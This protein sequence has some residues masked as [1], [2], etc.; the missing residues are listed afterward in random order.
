M[1][2]FSGIVRG[3]RHASSS[4]SSAEHSQDFGAYMAR[5]SNMQMLRAI[6]PIGTLCR[7]FGVFPFTFEVIGDTLYLKYSSGGWLLYSFLIFL[8]TTCYV[9]FQ[10][11]SL[12]LGI[13]DREITML[14]AQLL[15][16]ISAIPG[17]AVQIFM[18]FQG[19]VLIRLFEEWCSIEKIL[20]RLFCPVM[21]RK[22]IRRFEVFYATIAVLSISLCAY[23]AVDR[24]DTPV[25]PF[26]YLPKDSYNETHR[27]LYAAFQ[28]AII[29]WVWAGLLVLEGV[30]CFFATVIRQCMN[31]FISGMDYTFTSNKGR[32]DEVRYFYGV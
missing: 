28:T 21:T 10:A 32:A 7:L 8:I 11:T 3:Q 22:H 6:R 17:Y 23:H 25:Y 2:L 13:K 4:V 1:R 14:A 24:Y 5:F 20:E 12:F 19:K 15:W 31:T 27:W 9:I 26:F 16:L 30:C 29:G 18:F